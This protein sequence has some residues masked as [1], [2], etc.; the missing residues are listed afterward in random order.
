VPTNLNQWW[1]WRAVLIVWLA[2][3]GLY[4]QAAEF[5]YVFDD[6]PAVRD[7][8]S[9]SLPLGEALTLTQ[10]E[11]HRT[12]SSAHRKTT[13]DSF[14]PLRHLSLWV[15]RAAFGASPGPAHVH[16]ILMGSAA[17]WLV[18]LYLG[19]FP[20][21]QGV[22][23][24]V[25]AAFA[26]HPAQVECVAYVSGRSDIEAGLCGLGC[27][28]LAH[29]FESG[30]WSAQTLAPNDEPL[31]R[32]GLWA[33]LCA[34]LFA[35]CLAQKEAYLLLPLLV[36]LQPDAADRPTL[37]HPNLRRKLP[38]LVL[39]G[40]SAVGW[41]FV[42]SQMIEGAAPLDVK[43][44]LASA[45]ASLRQAFFIVVMPEAGSPLRPLA[46]GAPWL[47]TLAYG[48]LGLAATIATLRHK[49]AK[50]RVG[51]FGLVWFALLIG[52]SLVAAKYFA[53]LADRYLYLPLL[54]VL[55]SL[56]SLFEWFNSRSSKQLRL[57]TTSL[58]ALFCLWLIAQS[59]FT[60]PGWK[61]QR[62]LAELATQRAPQSGRSWIWLADEIAK[63]KGCA[64]A[65]PYFRKAA[66]VSPDYPVAWSNLAA[67]ALRSGDH[68]MAREY[69]E[70]AVRL[71]SGMHV[72]SWYN[73]GVAL[74]KLGRMKG[75]CGAYQ[76][77]LHLDPGHEGARV[78]TRRLCKK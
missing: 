57:A 25:T 19:L 22:R 15:D 17:V 7:N 30:S 39:L 33:V 5:D 31:A 36:L 11:H 71:S 48:A 56:G 8:P 18:W 67:C 58:A 62:T 9:M 6:V 51:A 14:R 60:I 41:F 46:K 32:R 24:G 49:S 59:A 52:P 70:K 66:A 78:A 55:V 29:R 47:E 44:S 26:F 40:A 34:L 45:G 69:G 74:E 54:G 50:V 4:A 37:D 27:L 2:F 65:L 1:G 3:L 20:F 38:L 76:S 12:A 16:N 61:N 28:L 43:G 72:P 10:H 68:Q 23:L 73:Y 21:S 75:A 35:A 53:V 63:D 64:G 13:H 77:A 42:R